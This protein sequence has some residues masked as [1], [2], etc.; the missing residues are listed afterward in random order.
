MELHELEPNKGE[1]YVPTYAI[2][3]GGQDLLR[4]LLLA[5]TSVE[6]D[7]KQK[8]AGHFNFTLKNAF[9]WE[10]REFVA[11]HE[12]KR[13]DLMELFAFGSAIE[14]SFGYG[15]PSK[16]TLL[17]KGIITEISTNFTE[18][19]SPGLTISG[20][21]G[22]Y[23]LT[24]GKNTRHWEDARDSEVVSDITG[25]ERFSIDVVQT[26]PVKPRI[27]QNQETD[28][29]FLSKLADR[30]GV[31]FYMRG[32]T[33]YFG[34]RHNDSSDVLE[35]PWGKGLLSF[36]PE[37]NLSK[38]ITSVEVSGWSAER[39]EA[40]VGRATRGEETGRDT[41]RQ[42]GADRISTAL[43]GES[44]MRIRAAVHTQAEADER[45]RAILEGRSEEFVKGNGESIGLPEIVPDINIAVTGLGNVFSKTYYV[46]ESTHKIDSNGYRNT[47]KIEETSV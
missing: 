35:L 37:V 38:Q 10:S 21:D 30:N 31:T 47:F 36:S 14:I 41:R 29:A 22:L 27:D 44:L 1:F 24:V 9:D 40:I 23:P 16:L 28:I 17:L 32:D 43:G 25:G 39:G 13:I 45:A 8:A 3:V 26:N 46:C 2:K 34:P 12:E 5:I 42:S 18:G 4:D 19:G 15:D 20:Y 6:V 7:L 11:E 33:F